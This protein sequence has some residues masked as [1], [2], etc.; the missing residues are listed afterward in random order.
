MWAGAFYV[1][2][3]PRSFIFSSGRVHQLIVLPVVHIPSQICQIEHM[4]M[5]EMKRNV[6]STAELKRRGETLTRQNSRTFSVIRRR[7]AG[8]AARPAGWS[9]SSSCAFTASLFPTMAAVRAGPLGFTPPPNFKDI[10]K[11][12]PGRI[13]STSLASGEP[14][15]PAR[16]DICIVDCDVHSSGPC[17]VL[18]IPQVPAHFFVSLSCTIASLAEFVGPASFCRVD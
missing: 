11:I 6:G 18:I 1:G 10:A 15:V 2:L 13:V 5:R 14:P 8:P 3:N 7:P 4:V 9:F 17:C 12:S 16:F